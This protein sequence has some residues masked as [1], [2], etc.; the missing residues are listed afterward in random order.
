MQ[1]NETGVKAEDSTTKRGGNQLKME[2]VNGH[3]E[4]L[5]SS[6]NHSFLPAKHK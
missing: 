4:A 5:V 2:V 1:V 6:P 3:L